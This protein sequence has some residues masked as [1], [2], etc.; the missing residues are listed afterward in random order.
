[1]TNLLLIYLCTFITKNVES[2]VWYH[3]Y[4]VFKGLLC[5]CQQ[6]DYEY[7]WIYRVGQKIKPY[8]FT[9]YVNNAKC[10]KK[11]VVLITEN[12]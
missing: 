8:I 10:T 1:M 9:L 5:E 3:I 6:Y 2:C 7:E 12:I 4:V 11:A